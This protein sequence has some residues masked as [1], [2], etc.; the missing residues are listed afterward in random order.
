MRL[1]KTEKEPVHVSNTK[2]LI[3]FEMKCYRRQ[4]LMSLVYCRAIES[5]LPE[6]GSFDKRF[7][8]R[9]RDTTTPIR[10]SHIVKERD[11]GTKSKSRPGRRSKTV[12]YVRFGGVDVNVP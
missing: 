7:S 8:G 10:C 2:R 1:L 5:F 4:V 6:I 9:G 11:V 3:S 12:A